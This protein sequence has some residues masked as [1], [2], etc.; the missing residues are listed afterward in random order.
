MSWQGAILCLVADALRRVNVRIQTQSQCGT[1]RAR[2]VPGVGQVP[3]RA[4]VVGFHGQGPPALSPSA[5]L[6]ILLPKIF[7]AE[8]LSNPHHQPITTLVRWIF[9]SPDPFSPPSAL[10]FFFCVCCTR[11]IS[12]PLL[13]FSSRP[14][15]RNDRSLSQTPTIS[16]SA[17]PFTPSRNLYPSACLGPPPSRHRESVAFCRLSSFVREIL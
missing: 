3:S 8:L 17:D 11:R 12:F 16:P 7:F 10:V 9:P 4:R 2:V 1:R 13:I 6:I 14:P 5:H 15:P